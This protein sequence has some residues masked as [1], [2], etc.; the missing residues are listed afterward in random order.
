M[1]G[2]S[3]TSIIELAGSVV[4]FFIGAVLTALIVGMLLIV[5]YVGLDRIRDGIRGLRSVTHIVTTDPIEPSEAPESGYATIVGRATDGPNGGLETPF[6]GQEALGYRYRIE[7][8]TDGVGWWTVA[9]GGAIG[10]FVLEGPTGRVLVDGTGATPN[11]IDRQL[12][13]DHGSGES[14]AVAQPRIEQVFD[15]TVVGHATGETVSDPRRYEEGTLDPGQELYVYGACADDSTYDGRIDA[16][17]S[18]TFVTDTEPPDE[19]L[20]DHDESWLEHGKRILSGVLAALIGGFGL[21]VVGSAIVSGLRS[22][23]AV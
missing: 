17:E 1:A 21:Y 11:G 13:A 10:E 12:V 16:T 8:E 20:D 3:V 9:E 4:V 6:A 14:M 7:Q 22:V 23:F 15:D 18:S 2:D 19:V 5:C